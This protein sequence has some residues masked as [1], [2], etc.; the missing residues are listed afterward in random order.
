MI[1]SG[2]WPILHVTLYVKNYMQ[3]NMAAN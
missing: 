3:E 2:K 1:N